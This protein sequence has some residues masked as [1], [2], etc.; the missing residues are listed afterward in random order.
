VIWQHL[1][2]LGRI[3]DTL[4]APDVP[5]GDGLIR[6]ERIVDGQLR[7]AVTQGVPYGRYPSYAIDRA[8]GVVWADGAEYVIHLNRDGAPRTIIGEWQSVPVPEEERAQLHKL[9]EWNLRHTDP[10]WSWT[11]PPIPKAKPPY[12]GLH[13]GLDDRIWVSL[14]PPSEGFS[15]NRKSESPSVTYRPSMRIWDVFDSNGAYLK[16]IRG[17]RTLKIFA[18]RGDTVWGVSRGE[19]D[20]PIISCLVA[21]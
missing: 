19:Y 2:S 11:G 12:D 1:D 10:T 3:R 17:P 8:G 18:T 6:A 9:I 15:S 13:I 14:S 21:Q 16:R 20:E 4:F 7:S 5:A